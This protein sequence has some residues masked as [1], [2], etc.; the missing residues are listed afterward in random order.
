MVRITVITEI[1]NFGLM[2]D[3]FAYLHF[4]ADNNEGN[5]NL[6]SLY[7]CLIFTHNAFL[8]VS[9]INAK[10]RTELF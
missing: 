5:L 4:L 9:L 2:Y 10:Q 3:M 1:L 8:I 7:P 6:A